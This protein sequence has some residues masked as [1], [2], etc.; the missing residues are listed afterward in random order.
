VHLVGF[1]VKKFVTMHG[2]M[3]VK[4]KVSNV[5]DKNCKENQN[6]HFVFSSPTPTIVPFM[7]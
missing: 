6:T 3:D 4:K 1:I 2:H 7:R 5:S